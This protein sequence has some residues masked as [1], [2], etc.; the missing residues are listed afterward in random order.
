MLAQR[1]P[2]RLVA[3]LTARLVRQGASRSV[4]QRWGFWEPNWPLRL[5]NK[6]QAA[7]KK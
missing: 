5:V 2:N 7:I 4:W 6:A 1:P 3:H